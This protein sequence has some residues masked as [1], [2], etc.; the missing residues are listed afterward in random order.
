MRRED[1]ELPGKEGQMTRF[2]N[3]LA[4]YNGTTGSEAVLEQA[5][6]VAHAGQ[7]RLTLLKQLG[8][9]DTVDEA[10]KRLRRI[11]PW[12]VQQGVVKV[13][14]DV[15]VDRSHREIVRRVAQ[16]AHD[17]VIV[18]AERAAGLRNAVFGDFGTS[19]M[20]YCP[21]PVWI[22][23]PEQAVPCAR[24]LA[25]VGAGT[26][27]G[28]RDV[29]GRIVALGAALARSHD[30]ELH[31]VHAWT[32]AGEDAALLTNEISDETREGIIRRNETAHRC[33]INALLSRFPVDGLDHQVHLPRGLP[34]QAIV[35]LAGRLDAD[36]VVMGSNSRTGLPRL[37]LGNPA[38]TVFGTV[39]CS[40]LSVNPDGV[41]LPGL[42]PEAN[43]ARRS[44]TMAEAAD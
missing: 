21:C 44:Q 22:L 28:S 39:G 35:A 7:A 25:A 36:V 43:G 29:N 4:V 15:T 5:V 32:P 37:L 26:D 33:A 30:A 10:Q 41:G 14:T 6:A 20:R 11:L 18:S 1:R 9:G 19:L 8:P 2:H 34:Q 13:E 40:V 3:I 38:V 24:I 42:A 12:I 31:I 27:P 23:R 17:L 16:K